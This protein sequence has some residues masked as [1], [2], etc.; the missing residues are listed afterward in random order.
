MEIKRADGPVHL[1]GAPGLT[2]RLSV[3]RHRLGGLT[4]W[5]DHPADVDRLAYHTGLI[6]AEFSKDCAD[7]P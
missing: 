6:N 5:Q 3:D 1:A 7:R 4:G 2:A